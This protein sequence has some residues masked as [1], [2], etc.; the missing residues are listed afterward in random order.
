MY[1][2]FIRNFKTPFEVYPMIDTVQSYDISQT[3]PDSYQKGLTEF[4]KNGSFI[5]LNHFVYPF[6]LPA[7]QLYVS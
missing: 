3:I 2:L 4:L 1:T 5:S 6:A 7:D